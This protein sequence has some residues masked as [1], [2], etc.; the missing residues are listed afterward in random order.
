MPT[1]AYRANRTRLPRL[2][3]MAACA[4]AEQ[5][6]IDSLGTGVISNRKRDVVGM[7]E[8]IEDLCKVTWQ[9]E[10]ECLCRADRSPFEN[11]DQDLGARVVRRPAL[12]KP[13]M[14]VEDPVHAHMSQVHGLLSDAIMLTTAR[15]NNF[16]CEK[17]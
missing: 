7:A 17:E 12:D 4:M 2:G 9:I 6:R 5:A 11:I 1:P 3:G 8:V 13:R 15:R 16:A 14:Q 10:P